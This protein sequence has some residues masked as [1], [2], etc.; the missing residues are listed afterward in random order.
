MKKRCI[1]RG[2]FQAPSKTYLQKYV[3]LKINK[4]DVLKINKQIEK[5]CFEHLQNMFVKAVSMKCM[6]DICEYIVDNDIDSIDSKNYYP[7]KVHGYR[8][9]YELVQNKIDSDKSII[10]RSDVLEK[11]RLILQHVVKKICEEYHNPT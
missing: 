7:I 1:L 8:M 10:L 2:N 5:Y 4:D 9:L 6:N 3:D 11:F